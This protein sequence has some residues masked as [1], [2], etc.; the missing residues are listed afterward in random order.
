MSLEIQ[1]GGPHVSSLGETPAFL[2]KELDAEILTGFG[3]PNTIVLLKARS[4]GITPDSILLCGQTVSGSAI[5]RELAPAGEGTHEK[6]H[7]W[8]ICR[9]RGRGDLG[10][11]NPKWDVSIKS[12]P[13]G[14][15]ELCKSQCG[16]KTPKN[17]DL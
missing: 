2:P 13:S 8:T 11:L 5:I 16:W 15:R 9:G 3:K 12:L 10:I 1:N 14:L 6:S 4:N 17:Q 7:N